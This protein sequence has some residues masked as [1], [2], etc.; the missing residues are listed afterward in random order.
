M[1]RVKVKRSKGEYLVS[2]FGGVIVIILGITM[3]PSFFGTFK[4]FG[5]VWIILGA[6]A[7][8]YNLYAAFSGKGIPLYEMDMDN[9]GESVESRLKKLDGL[10]HQGLISKEEWEEKRK[11][12]LNEI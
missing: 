1:R 3:I 5:L 11:S 12:I 10:Y 7:V 2:A 6:V 9:S 4:T 8:V